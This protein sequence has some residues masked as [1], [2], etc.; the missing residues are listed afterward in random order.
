LSKLLSVTPARMTTSRSGFSGAPG[1]LDT[2]A[3]EELA[4]I[5]DVIARDS[6]QYATLVV[7]RIVTAVDILAYFPLSGRIVPERSREDCPLLGCRCLNARDLRP[8]RARGP[9][10]H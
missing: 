6:P 7:E 10:D 1:S 2:S 4:A 3:A 5:R 8:E 9:L